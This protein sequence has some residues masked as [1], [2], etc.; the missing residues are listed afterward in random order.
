MNTGQIYY[1]VVGDRGVLKLTGALRYPLSE[2]LAQ[3][4]G[5][6]F[7]ELGVHCVIV[8]LREALFIDSTCLGLLA[9]VGMRCLELGIEA[10]VM[11]SSNPQ[12][13][14]QLKTTGLDQAFALI[15]ESPELGFTLSDAAALAPE[16]RRPDP[17][18]ILEAH[19][20]LCDLN[21]NNRHLFQ[22]VVEVLQQGL[23][24]EDWI[25]AARRPANGRSDARDRP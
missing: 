17:K 15:E 20:A 11:V 12:V 4:A 2:R 25:A 16:V 21:Q 3:A 14:L 24:G 19:R 9:R 7:N 8:D 23:S 6:L 22:S 18:L 5:H 1:A 10:P 13:T